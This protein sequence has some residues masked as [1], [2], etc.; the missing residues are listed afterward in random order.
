MKKTILA[1]LISAYVYADT[2]IRI[3]NLNHIYDGDTIY[4]DLYCDEPLFCKNIG[5]RILGVDTPEI[6]S[7]NPIDRVKAKIAKKF[8]ENFQLGKV[9]LKKCSRDKYFRIDCDIVNDKNQSLG[10]ELIKNGH[11]YEYF[12]D[13]KLQN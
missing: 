2:S 13:T 1:L 8:T 6:K 11:G 3:K 5:V 7:S 10:T 9:E 4:V 12:G